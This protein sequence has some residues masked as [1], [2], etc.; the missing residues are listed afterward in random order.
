MFLLSE[1]VMSIILPKCSFTTLINIIQ[2]ILTGVDSL[3]SIVT[4]PVGVLTHLFSLTL[5]DYVYFLSSVL[6]VL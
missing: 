4:L 1:S 6:K 2:V 5:I 3:N